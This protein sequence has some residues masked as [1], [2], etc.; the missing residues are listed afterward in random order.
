MIRI[1]NP[2]SRIQKSRVQ[3][4]L[5]HRWNMDSDLNPE[6]RIQNLESGVQIA[7]TNGNWNPKVGVNIQICDPDSR[8]SWILDCNPRCEDPDNLESRL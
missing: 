8:L 3:L 5:V 1:Q 6:S 7:C 4:D 2:E